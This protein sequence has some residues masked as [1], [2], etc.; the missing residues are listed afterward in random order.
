VA[1]GV[2]MA[3]PLVVVAFASP[4]V[5]P[6]P[7]H[8]PWFWLLVVTC[9]SVPAF[10]GG[11]V[12][13]SAA[14]AVL[15][16]MGNRPTVGSALLSRAAVSVS[17]LVYAVLW[18]VLAA[19]GTY[20]LLAAG[21][22]TLLAL[23]GVLIIHEPSAGHRLRT[24]RV[25]G[26]FGIVIVM[27]LVLPRPAQTWLVTRTG[28]RARLLESQWLTVSQWRD[29]DGEMQAEPLPRRRALESRYARSP[30]SGPLL[31][32]QSVPPDKR[33]MGLFGA[34][35][36]LM[37]ELGLHLPAE[38]LHSFDPGIR[39]LAAPHGITS[40]PTSRVSATRALRMKR[41]MAIVVIDLHTLPGPVRD[42]LL[43]TGFLDR[44]RSALGPDGMA[45]LLVSVQSMSPDELDRWIRGVR[46]ISGDR[47]GWTCL[48]ASWDSV[49]VLVFGGDGQWQDRWSLWSWHPLR[50]ASELP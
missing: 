37:T 33:V 1:A 20:A 39:V 36:R 7:S 40:D 5:G 26:V 23:G 17:V 25:A 43:R 21:A 34:S 44:V 11:Y 14:G 6:A 45:I 32:M 9:V 13:G 2:A 48:D 50:P 38:A 41:E 19:L 27:T 4:S 30:V 29:G 12:T 15:G 47:L 24:R 31:S 8:G 49:L 42:R 16:R 22:L 46:V 28:K 18:P 10:A 35:F 3:I